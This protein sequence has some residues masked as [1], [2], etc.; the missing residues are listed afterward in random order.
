[1]ID[2][3]LS[4]AG[5]TKEDELTG[6]TT[7]KYLYVFEG[8][9]YISLGLVLLAFAMVPLMLCVKPFVL[10][11]QMKNHGHG[12]NVHVHTESVQYEKNPEGKG[13]S[14]NEVYEKISSILEKEGSG[15]DHH[16]FSE[17]FIH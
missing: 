10:R 4:A 12:P 7:T 5:N 2:I 1:M 16:D 15:K 11:S 17:I 9:K 8:Q 14:R 6:V 3:F 13:S